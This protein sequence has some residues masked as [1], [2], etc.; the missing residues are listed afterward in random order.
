MRERLRR[1]NRRFAVAIV[2]GLIAALAPV[3]SAARAADSPPSCRDIT[4]PVSLAEGHPKN[5]KVSGR[6]CVPAGARP[7][8]IQLL[9]HGITYTREY[10]SFP[11]PSGHT[12]RYDYVAAATEAGFATLAI[13]RIGAGGSSHPLSSLVTIESNAHAVHDVVRAIR[14]GAVRSPSGSRFAKIALV[15]HSYG[16]WVGWYE[17]STYNDVDA[18]VITGA[19][20][21]LTP[22]YAPVNVVPN[23]YPALL[24]PQFGIKLP[25]PGYVTTLPGKRYDMFYAPAEVDPAVIAYDEAHKGTMTETEI[26]TYPLILGHQLD[27]RVPVLLV[28]GTKDSLFCRPELG[29]AD[30]SSPQALIA[31]EAKYLGSDV[32]SVDAYIDPLAGHNLDM[33]P[34]ARSTFRA[35]QDWIVAK[36]GTP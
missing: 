15:G 20:H 24:D 26:A 34:D 22:L 13:D 10:W 27:I 6:L 35:I 12:D 2:G 23:L 5:Q 8:T 3:G 30:C 28:A 21:K 25:D 9:V 19:T 17:T 4:V 33:S 36:A 16:S 14:S 11:D 1:Y 29:G 18:F 31:D 7:D 32:P